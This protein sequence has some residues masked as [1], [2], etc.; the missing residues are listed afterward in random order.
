MG[1]V[2]VFKTGDHVRHKDC[3]HEEGIVLTKSEDPLEKN[4]YF[5]VF[6][7]GTQYEARPW[8]RYLHSNK[9]RLIERELHK[10]KEP[11][12]FKK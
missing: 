8:L 9:L 7:R 11:P 5:V 1:G 2:R 3:V 6:C 12:K 4:Y 10:P